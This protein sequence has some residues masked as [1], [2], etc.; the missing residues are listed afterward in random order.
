MSVNNRFIRVHQNAIVEWIWDDNFFYA[1]N[2]SIIDDS[3]NG[4]SSFTFSENAIDSDNYNKMPQQLYLVDDII[5]KFG[6]VNPKD[7]S[8][9]QE[10]KYNNPSPSK[11]NKVKIWFPINYNFNTDIGFYLKTYT[12]NYENAI[13][14]NL[15]NYFLDKT[16][17]GEL[18]KIINESVPFRY[19][20]KLW[21]KSVEIYVPS[22]YDEALNRTNGMPTVGTINNQL[23]NGSLGLSQTSPIF[24]DFRFLQNKSEILGE[25]TY[26]STPKKVVSI[27]QA[28][29]YNNLGVQIIEAE[30]GDYFKINGIYNG[31]IGG[32]NSFM[33]SLEQS[34]ASSYILYS[35]TVFEENIAQDTRDIYVYKDFFKGV[36]DYVPVLKFTNT[37]ATIRVDMKLINSIDSSVITKSTE[38]SIV[39]NDV[40][41]YSKNKSVINVSNAYKPKLY[42]SKPDTLVLPNNDLLD[43]HL[44]KMK[45]NHGSTDVKFIPFPVLTN[46]H[47]VVALDTSVNYKNE[48]YKGSGELT[49]NLTP[50]DNVVKLT[51]FKYNSDN[52][53]TPF[54]IPTSNTAVQMVFKIDTRE[55]R[56]PLYRESNEVDLKNGTVVFKISE[57]DQ[58]SIKVIESK[59]NSFYITL[60]SNGIETN[61]YD[62]K[63]NFLSTKPRNPNNIIN[64]IE[65]IASIKKDIIVEPFE[66]MTLDSKLTRETSIINQSTINNTSLKSINKMGLSIK[67]LNRIK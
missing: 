64:K 45:R 50:F 58:K 19:G 1:D 10:R 56:I 67:Q 43:T 21:G 17:P 51:I 25:T 34:N 44:R 6:I 39:G 29:E 11:F 28:P 57:S 49:L 3:K 38:Y 13:E 8:F 23:T 9:L 18:S 36:D 15:S 35:V 16:I 14:Y 47:K 20:E 53:I 41:K 59:N 4:V 66:I 60:T 55:V 24:I 54:E 48:V 30:D 63:F 33:A 52:D 12:L 37:T 22:V 26:I 40:A 62:G 27:P 32:F 7:K 46:I 5:N 61:L 31:S 2:Y 65:P 42:N